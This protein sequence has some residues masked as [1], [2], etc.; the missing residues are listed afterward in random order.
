MANKYLDEAGLT[1]FW[2]KLKDYFQ[3][4]LVSGTNIKTIN[5][6]S[7]LG[8]GNMVI[9]GGGSVLDFY[10]VGSFY[11]TSDA[12]FDPNV[13]WGGTWTLEASGQVHVSAGTGYTIGDTGG[14]SSVTL[15]AS[16]IPSHTHGNKSLTG[17]F[18]VRRYGTS[19]AGAQIAFTPSGIVSIDNVASTIGKINIGGTGNN[20]SYEL[21]TVNASHEHTSVGGGQ[22]HENMPP[23]VVVNRWHRTA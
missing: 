19:G 17:S 12:S 21:I 3:A 20:G 8:S 13:S 4:K 16:E 23:Y 6:Q 15:G 5:S 9:G 18:E 22:A 2:G 1:Y 7:I 11:E 14:A 10:P